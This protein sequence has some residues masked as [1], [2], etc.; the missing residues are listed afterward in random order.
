MQNNMY[1]S[2][3]RFIVIYSS[4]TVLHTI[5]VFHYDLV[6]TTLLYCTVY[7]YW[8]R[9]HKYM[10]GCHILHYVIE[11]AKRDPPPHQPLSYIPW[12]PW[13]ILPFFEAT[14]ICARKSMSGARMRLCDVRERAAGAT[15]DASPFR[16]AAVEFADS[17]S[18]SSF[19]ALPPTYRG[20]GWSY[21]TL[22]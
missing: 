9:L 22:T 13:R 5:R 4:Y 16:R 20:S 1:N 11:W 18:R 10:L 12:N 2:V 21:A 19:A 17:A 6:S 3:F 14:A 15:A 7:L 8:I